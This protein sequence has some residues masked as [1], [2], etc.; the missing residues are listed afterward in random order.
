MSGLRHVIDRTNL[1]EDV[2]DM[3]REGEIVGEYPLYTKF[4]GEQAVDEGGV[5]RDM[6]SAFWAE[7][8]TRFLEGAKTLTPMIHPGLDMAVYPI[9]GRVTSHGISSQLAWFLDLLCLFPLILF[10]K[11]AINSGDEDVVYCPEV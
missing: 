8:Y 10:L 5:Q 11:T 1:Y 9:L 3:Y 2:V 7:V 6:L 4:Q